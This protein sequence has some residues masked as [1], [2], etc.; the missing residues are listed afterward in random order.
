MYFGYPEGLENAPMAA[1]QAGLSI[2]EAVIKTNL[3]WEAAGRSQL[4][5]RIGIHTGLVVVD[6]HL[7]LGDTVNIAARLEGLAPHNG[8]VISPQTLKLVQGWFEFKSTGK[9]SLKGISEPM[10]VFQVLRETAVKTPLEAAK[11]RGLS[12]L[13][14]R[15]SE[16]SLLKK[17]WAQTKKGKG[18]LTLLNGEAGIG[19]SRLVDAMKEQIK[20]DSDSWLAEARCSLYHRNSAF[21][22]IIEL[23]EKIVLQF[24]PQDLPETKLTK[25]KDFLLETDLDFQPAMALFAEFL[26]IPSEQFPPT[27]MS[28][29][30][31]KQRIMEGLDSA[32]SL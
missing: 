18:H 24:E 26:S 27:V 12:P 25:L 20:K 19:K 14:G 22:P 11:S 9:H 10:E 15:Q 21:Y 13:V 30:A 16:L 1:V 5:I 7:A 17:S 31:K 6:E 23:L 32:I 4:K 29:F 2:I 8:L 3:D 28:P